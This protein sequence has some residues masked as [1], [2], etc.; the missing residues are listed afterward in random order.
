MKVRKRA[1]ERLFIAIFSRNLSGS[2]PWPAALG[3][4]NLKIYG[5]LRVSTEI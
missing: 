4:V 2:L 1:R 5:E 3:E